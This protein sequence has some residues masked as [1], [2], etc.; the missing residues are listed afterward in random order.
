MS[1]IAEKVDHVRAAG[2]DRS[3]HCHWPGC[4]KQVP[5]AKWGCKDHW[6]RLPREIRTWIWRA[7]HIGQEQSG[8][9]STD[10]VAAARAAQEWIAM[11]QS[12]DGKQLALFPS[13]GAA[14]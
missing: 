6:Y 13:I 1:A 2:Q 11:Q 9:P 8:R 12:R 10:Y 3:H 4:E 5:P 7:Y 14:R